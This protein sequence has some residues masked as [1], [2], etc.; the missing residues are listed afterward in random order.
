MVLDNSP[1]LLL[2]IEALHINLKNKFIEFLIRLKYNLKYTNQKIYRILI[3][4]IVQN[5]S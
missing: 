2:T 1:K 5:T 4:K 3:I